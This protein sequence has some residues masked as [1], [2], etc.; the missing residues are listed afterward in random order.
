MSTSADFVVIGKITTVYGVKGWV[1]VHAFTDPIS[2][3]F[4]YSGF[5]IRKKGRW[6]PIEIDES[7]MHG[8]GI[9]AHL[10][11]VDDR[12]LAREYC[13]LELGIVAETLPALDEGEYYWHELIGLKVYQHDSPEQLLGQVDHLMETGANDVL[14][15][16]AC[17]G[18]ID[19][20][21]RL[22]PYVPD[23]FV[24]KIDVPNGKMTVDW[25][26]EF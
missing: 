25:D 7:R 1:K 23:Q 4:D 21:E 13:G 10:Q 18:S 3:F 12:E 19:S 22:I 5:V 17:E 20:R 8:K 9:V 14:V 24:R 11:G 2:N 6:Q 16:K 15:L 26:P